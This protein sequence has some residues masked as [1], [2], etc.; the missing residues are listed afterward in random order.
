MPALAFDTHAYVK[1]LRDAGMP[2]QQAE[3]QVEAMLWLIEGRMATKQDLEVHRAELKRDL[4][5]LKR[6][7]KALDV[8]L[9]AGLKEQD[10]KLETRLR[11]LENKLIIRLGGL[12]FVGIGALAALIKLL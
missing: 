9:A 7:V 1:K 2:E 5:E 6:D 10:V 8:K 4:A 11:E 12:F 3:V